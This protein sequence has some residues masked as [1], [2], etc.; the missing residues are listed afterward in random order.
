MCTWRHREQKWTVCI[1]HNSQKNI[2]CGG[3]FKHSSEGKNKANGLF[4]SYS[5]IRQ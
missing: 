1:Q 3:M 5:E 4:I 2:S